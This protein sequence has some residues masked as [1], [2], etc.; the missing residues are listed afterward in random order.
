MT[1]GLVKISGDTKEAVVDTAE[2]VKKDVSKGLRQY[3][4]KAIDVAR[5]IPGGIG[6]KAVKYPW[7]VVSIAL[8]VG[9]LLGSMLRPH[10]QAPWVA[11]I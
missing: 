11:Q 8:G 7:V 6:E 9:L 2:S 3:N 4:A 1:E 10:R 5:K